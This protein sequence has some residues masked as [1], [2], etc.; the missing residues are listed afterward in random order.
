MHR[1]FFVIKILTSNSL[2]LKILQTLFAEPAPVKP[3][4]GGWGEG[5]PPNS[6]FF[7]QMELAEI[8]LC[9]DLINY[10]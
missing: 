3:F 10:F 5:V 8:V 7:P 4:R 9:P 1:K 6:P 2:G